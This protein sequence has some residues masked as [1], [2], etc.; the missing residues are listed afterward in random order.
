MPRLHPCPAILLGGH[1][2][3]RP[4]RRADC[5]HP[6]TAHAF[7]QDRVGGSRALGPL[8]APPGVSPTG[9]GHPDERYSLSIAGAQV[10]VRAA[11]P[12]GVARGLTT[13]VQL[14]AVAP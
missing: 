13:L 4:A 12:V 1:A 10:A 2:P 3:H 7:G 11:E 8:A 6:G 5:R 9:N 14:L